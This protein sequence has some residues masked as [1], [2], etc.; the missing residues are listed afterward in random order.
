M[1]DFYQKIYPKFDIE[2]IKDNIEINRKLFEQNSRYVRTALVAYNAYFADGSDFSKKDY[3][4][5]IVYD[6]LG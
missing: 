1:V 4:E 3:L 5:R 2:K 6:A